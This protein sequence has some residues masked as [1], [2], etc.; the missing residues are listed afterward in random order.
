MGSRWYSI[1]VVVLWLASMAWLVT[2]KILPTVRVGEPPGY[3]VSGPTVGWKIMFRGEQLGWAVSTVTGLPNNT[4]EVRSYVHF[5]RVPLEQ[6]IP[7]R[8]RG[9]LQLDKSALG[10]LKLETENTLLIDP[11]GRLVDFEAT[12]RMDRSRDVIKIRGKVEGTQWEVSVDPIGL[13]T[14]LSVPPKAFLGD[15]ISPQARLTGL[16]YGQTWTVPSYSFQRDPKDPVEILQAKVEEQTRITWN[17]EMYR[18]WLVVYRSDPGVRSEEKPRT[19]LW[20]RCRTGDVLRQEVS[21]FGSE[22]LF[23]RMADSETASLDSMERIR[24]FP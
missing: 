12:L 8:L 1:A 18:V 17:G 14:K 4:T 6:L 2:Q 11:L 23:V 20:V 10:R 7:E 24:R 5:D 16:R 15:A 22:L 9:P 19:R 21:L 13:T 3:E